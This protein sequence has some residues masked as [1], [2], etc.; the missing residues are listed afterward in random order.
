M[1]LNFQRKLPNRRRPPHPLRLPPAKRVALARAVY[2]AASF[3]CRFSWYISRS[4]WA[5]ISSSDSVSM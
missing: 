5:S 4:A 3:L 2:P 1:Q